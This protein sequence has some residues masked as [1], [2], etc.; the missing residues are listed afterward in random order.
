MSK[1]PRFRYD[2]PTTKLGKR[3]ERVRQKYRND[4]VWNEA[5]P[6]ARRPSPIRLIRAMTLG[7]ASLPVSVGAALYSSDQLPAFAR[8]V[9]VPSGLD[10]WSVSFRELRW[11]QGWG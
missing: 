5:L 4:D 3:A 7:F 9:A 8:W 2:R 6:V 11:D 10:A 1:A